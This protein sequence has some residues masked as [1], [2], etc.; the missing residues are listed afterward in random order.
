MSDIQSTMLTEKSK[1][2]NNFYIFISLT[3]DINQGLHSPSTVGR[4][5][6]IMRKAGMR[7]KL[8]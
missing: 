6:V 3:L 8:I 1:G 4:H 7:T 2:K 5:F